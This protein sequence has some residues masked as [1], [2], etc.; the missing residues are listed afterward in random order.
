MC[1]V[2]LT[3]FLL[4]KNLLFLFLY[5]LFL[6]SCRHLSQEHRFLVLLHYLLQKELEFCY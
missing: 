6:I 5:N 3:L 2:Y 4:R 1:L